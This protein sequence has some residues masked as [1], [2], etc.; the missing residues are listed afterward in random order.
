MTDLDK[1]I[2]LYASLGIKCVVWNDAEDDTQNITL[3]AG[4]Y[5]ADGTSTVSD[6]IKGYSG[7]VSIIIFDMDGE[8]KSQ[9]MWE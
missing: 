2:E 3:E 7:F 6:K 4:G 8:F 9:G 5:S 1:F